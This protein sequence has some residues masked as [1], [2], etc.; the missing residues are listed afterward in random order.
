[1]RYRLLCLLLV[2]AV[3]APLARAADPAPT[4]GSV[5]FAPVGNEGRL[6]K[7]FRLEPHTFEYKMTPV[8]TRSAVSETSLVTFPSP[9][10]TPYEC[11]N[12][13]HCEY[14]CPTAEGQ[15]PG[16]IVLHIL[17]GDFD[18]ARLFCRALAGKGVSAL[19]LKMPYYGERR[20]KDS[21]VRMISMDPYETV[22]GMTQAVLDIRRAAAW[23]AARDE[24]IDDEVGIMGI[25]LGGITAALSCS[26][27]PRFHKAA[28][29]L[30]GG[31]M[32]EVAWT[33][34]EMEGLREK[35]TSGGHTKKELFD[36]LR[37]VDPV[38]Y[39]QP[40]AGRKILM[41]NAS[42]DEVVPPACTKSLWRAF[43][44]PE[45]IWWDAGHYSAVRYL[46]GGMMRVVEFFQSDK[47]SPAQ[48]TAV[49][50]TAK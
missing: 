28:L 18:L 48:S 33:S 23:L 43:G 36:I 25:S 26:I 9:V 39:A 17:G 37:V 13:V 7:Q 27:E 24:V 32:G 6:P 12:T 15:R 5:K 42:H 49:Q 30:A 44:E 4:T 46:P 10:V 41:L 11:N 21:P 22:Q 47:P 16:V 8:A 1:M 50:S 3:S 20:P 29:L 35:W 34:T 14:F 38:T 40:V 2:V 45:I 19:F 31:D